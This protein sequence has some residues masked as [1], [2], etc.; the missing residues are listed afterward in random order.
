M[1][2]SMRPFFREFEARGPRTISG[3]GI[4]FDAN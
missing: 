3:P 4:H 2:R 1:F